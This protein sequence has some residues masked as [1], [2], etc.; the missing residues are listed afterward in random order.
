M[1]VA[2]MKRDGEGEQDDGGLHGVLPWGRQER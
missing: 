1:G 2:R